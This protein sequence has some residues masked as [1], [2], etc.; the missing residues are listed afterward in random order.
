MNGFSSHTDQ[1]GLLEWLSYTQNPKK[2]FLIH[3]ER[4]K[5]TIFQQKLKESLGF[6]TYIPTYGE[7]LEL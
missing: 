3:G 6:D 5:M 4:E 7:L 2:V 1:E